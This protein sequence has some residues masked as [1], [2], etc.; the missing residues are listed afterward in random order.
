M[1]VPA[2]GRR[3]VESEDG[4]VRVDLRALSAAAQPTARTD[5]GAGAKADLAV[6][7]DLLV[8]SVAKLPKLV[9][10]LCAA[11]L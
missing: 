5:D 6:D 3:R 11:P 9:A 10:P 1:Q 4:V 8:P 7:A 2:S